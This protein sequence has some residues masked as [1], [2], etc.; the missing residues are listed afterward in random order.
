MTKNKFINLVIVALAFLAVVQT[1]GL[2]LSQTQS[3]NLF[4][5][6]FNSFFTAGSDLTENYRPIEAESYAIGTGDNQYTLF[7]SG[8][9]DRLLN[10]AE[11]AISSALESGSKNSSGVLNWSIL[12]GKNIVITYP[13]AISSAEF[14]KGFSSANDEKIGLDNFSLIVI[15]PSFSDDSIYIT[16][17]NSG[18]QDFS[19]L[20]LVDK[21]IAASLRSV[22]DSSESKDITYISSAQSGFNIFK[23]NVFLPQ[24]TDTQYSYPSV[25]VVN[26]CSDQSGATSPTSIKQMVQPFFEPSKADGSSIDKSGVYLFYSDEIVVKYYPNGILEYFSYEKS[27]E[28]QTLASAYDACIKFIEKDTS[29]DTSYFLTDA[30]VTTEGLVFRFNYSVNGIP[31]ELNEKLKE[32]L[33]VESAIE[34]V[35]N[36]N[37]VK[38][39]RKY[40]YNFYQSTEKD[41]TANVDFL[42]EINRVITEQSSESEII[43]IDDL[44]LCYYSD[45]SSNCSLKWMTELDGTLHT[46]DVFLSPDEGES[47]LELK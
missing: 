4:Y 42:T 32:E 35:V 17:V 16:F 46:G 18:E 26:S 8:E 33:G 34:V 20:A 23:T 25:K 47:N 5:S 38:K 39:Y 14:A 45:G 2:W 11:K 36:N 29:I 43:Q 19:S 44:T 6:A 9:N 7:R 27:A 28:S 22:I 12:S 41:M 30:E 40:A 24:W 21:N 3:H 15:T 37:T 1:G 10:A 13:F 31:V